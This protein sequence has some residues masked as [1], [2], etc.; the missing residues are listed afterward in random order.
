[1]PVANATRVRWLV[2]VY[3]FAFSFL[4]IVDRVAISAAKGDMSRDLGISDVTFGF[5]FGVF[6]LGYAVF[7][8]PS[9]WAADRF[10]PRAFLALIV[11][12]WSVFTGLTGAVTASVALIAIRFLFGAAESGIYP[13]A[14][15]AIYSWIPRQGRGAAQ[16]LMFVGSR[17]G[18]AFGL[19]A[20]SFTIA[21]FGWR[22]SFWALAAVGVV[23][24]SGWYA[25]FR[26]HPAEKRSVSA[27][28]L[29]YIRS[30]DGA[31]QPPEASKGN[32]RE[33][34]LSMN[35]LLLMA[36][37]FASNFTF[38][39]AF[40]WLLPYLKS[41][42]NLTATGAGAYAS[43]PL[44]FGAFGN[45]FSG[46]LVDAIYRRG[47]WR[48]SRV[49]PALIGFAL[50]TV[51]LIAAASMPTV[52]GAVICF[53]LAT[54]G[55]DMTLSPSWTSCQDIAGPRTGVLSGA[56]NMIGNLGS[57]ISSV[58]FPLLVN[59]TGTAATYFY[60]AAAINVLA[61]LCW[62]RIRPDRS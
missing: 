46:T 13:T 8:V 4:T 3:L 55:V 27:A 9:G 33:L 29:E 7:Q 45:W 59:T 15:R 1:M 32:W 20:V 47:H 11:V 48:M 25:W 23:M 40:S 5:V 10:G 35:S 60:I 38:F 26:N 19:S 39:I 24:A 36:Q 43:V 54:L 14:S 18:A 2:V 12:L 44:Y 31:E 50:G 62:W 28:E 51:S 17:L 49:M 30:Q 21:S 61:I 53:S 52:M 58:M 37:Y 41:Q 42:Y 22:A 34:L 57:F 6:A 16:G 56:M